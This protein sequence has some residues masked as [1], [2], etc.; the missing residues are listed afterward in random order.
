MTNYRP[1]RDLV[2]EQLYAQRID[3]LWAFPCLRVDGLRTC[4][5]PRGASDHN[6]LSINPVHAL[7]PSERLLC[8]EEALSLSGLLCLTSPLI[9]FLPKSVS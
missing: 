3:W 2:V 1:E 5:I 9:V 8:A 6:V 4:Q 7:P